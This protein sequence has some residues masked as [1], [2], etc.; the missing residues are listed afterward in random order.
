MYLNE[1]LG[2]FAQEH[3][4]LLTRLRAGNPA[5]FLIVGNVYAPQT[6][7]AHRLAQALEEANSI[8]AANVQQ[9]GAHL[10]D[11][12][13]AFRG[14]EREYLCFDIEPSREGAAVIAGLF[15]EAVVNA[16]GI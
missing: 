2:S 8:I 3:L 13:R 12:Y 4:D 7:L 5:A 10:A 15:Q 6:P 16:G 11:I 1:G 14:H 9:V